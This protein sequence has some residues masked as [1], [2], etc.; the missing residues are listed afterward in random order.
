MGLARSHRQQTTVSS[1]PTICAAEP[2]QPGFNSA[3]QVTATTPEG[4]SS[5]RLSITYG[6]DHILNSPLGALDPNGPATDPV[7]G[8]DVVEPGEDCRTDRGPAVGGY[9]GYSQ[10]LPG[11]SAYVRLGEV[12]VHYAL[13]PAATQAQLDARVWDVPP[14]GHAFLMTRGTYR[15]DTLQGYDTP[16]GEVR[17]PLFGNHWLLAPGHRIR[18]DLTQVDSPTL[19]PNNAASSI[20]F[21]PRNSCFPRARRRPKRSPAR[22]ERTEGGGSNRLAVS[23]GGLAVAGSNPVASTDTANRGTVAAQPDQTAWGRGWRRPRKSWHPARTMPCSRGWT[24]KARGRR[25]AIPDKVRST[26]THG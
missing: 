18:L 12:D 16:S 11:H 20:T 7:F 6:G 5:G 17:L 13:T 24:R 19:R 14:S 10:P 26:C 1:E 2:D 23:A 21:G 4:L 9:T 22:P 25:F 3:D 15:F 8:G